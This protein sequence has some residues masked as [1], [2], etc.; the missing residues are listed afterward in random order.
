M[1]LL[2][3]LRLPAHPRS[4]RRGG[5]ARLLPSAP[6]PFSPLTQ[7]VAA[8]GPA[9]KS[10]TLLYYL[11]YI[12]TQLLT[13]LLLPFYQGYADAGDFTSRA[14]MRR[15]VRE[16]ATFYGVL[17]GAGCVS[18]VAV[19]VVEGPANFSFQGLIHSGIAF[20][21]SFSIA[22]G[23]LL[24]GYGLSEIP[25][26][27]WLRSVL[28][29]RQ[30]WCEHGVG[31]ISD[32]LSEA[33]TE[34]GKVVWSADQMS[35]TMPRRHALRWAMDIIDEC[36]RKV[37]VAGVSPESEEGDDEEYDYEDINVRGAHR[38]SACT[39]LTPFLQALA[40]LRCRLNRALI[41]FE[42]VKYEYMQ[43]VTVAIEVSDI[44]DCRLAGRSG[45]DHKFRSSLRPPRSGPN[46]ALKDRLEYQWKARNG[47][48]RRCLCPSSLFLRP[49]QCVARRYLM[50]T[51]AVVL[52][53]TSVIL[54][55]AEIT[56]WCVTVVG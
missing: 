46:A 28:T 42:R 23:M 21:L 13:W 12:L 40:N 33:H 29:T 41:A 52:A 11:P 19:V 30:R 53:L 7:T 36:V 4:S 39:P 45:G 1:P 35:T 55:L 54:I 10:L 44:V 49:P 56:I 32:Q 22:T 9:S 3:R 43:A 25:R 8:D 16:N 20:S 15:S 2:V 48:A 31:K 47:G 24:M 51:L 26:I 38:P 5:G 34:L 27:C 18:L 17:L 14:R 6:A 50:R 37:A